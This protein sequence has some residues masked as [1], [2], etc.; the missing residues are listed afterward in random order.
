MKYNAQ[1][2]P[3]PSRRSL[4]YAQNGMVCTSQPL[5]AN[6]GLDILKN[7]GN[8]IDAAVATAACL[9]VVEPT[10]NG[11]GSDAFALVWIEKEKK[12]YGLNASG[13]APMGINPQTVSYTHLR[14][15]ET[16][17]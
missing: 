7:G 8:A 10:S 13:K 17:S 9:T 6:A 1:D 16:D 14:A 3:F 15:H 2:Y 12:L 11:I 5:A 4:I